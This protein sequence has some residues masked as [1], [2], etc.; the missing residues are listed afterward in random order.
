[1]GNKYETTFTNWP[2]YLG[3]HQ[4]LHHVSNY[5]CHVSMCKRLSSPS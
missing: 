3:V 5:V 1:M 4:R 2:P